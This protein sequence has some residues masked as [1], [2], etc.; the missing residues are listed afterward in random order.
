MTGSIF[1]QVDGPVTGGLISDRLR[2]YKFH[3]NSPGYVL[4]VEIYNVAHH[5][6]SSLLLRRWD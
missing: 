4:S 1:L 5:V 3:E 2:Y 6:C